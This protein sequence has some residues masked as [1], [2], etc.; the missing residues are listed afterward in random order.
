[1]LYVTKTKDRG[2][3]DYLA[4]TI[5]VDEG[6]ETIIKRSSSGWFSVYKIPEHEAIEI[7]P[8]FVISPELYRKS[9]TIREMARDSFEQGRLTEEDYV[10]L[11]IG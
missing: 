10:R 2:Y 5:R 7:A 1:M 3:A 9:Y 4:R 11:Q 8:G 6:L